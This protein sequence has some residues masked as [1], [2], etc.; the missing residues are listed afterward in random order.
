[1]IRKITK[2]HIIGIILGI[3]IIILDIILLYPL[4]SRFFNAV[5]AFGAFIIVLPFFMDILKESKR[6]REM[7]EKFL[8]FTRNLADTVRSGI[9]IPKAIIQVS[10]AEYGA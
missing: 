1:M 9:P 5:I 2:K 10:E 3:L 4:E 8:E 6:Q 7:E